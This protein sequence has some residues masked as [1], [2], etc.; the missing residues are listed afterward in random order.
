MDT[1]NDT[2]R[3]VDALNS[4]LR[5]ELSAVETYEQAI[6]K[7]IDEPIPELEENRDSHAD[8][9]TVLSARVA[10]LGGIPETSSGAWGAFAKLVEGGAELFGRDAAIA[11]LEEGEDRGLND[12]RTALG[13]LD[14]DSRVVVVADLLPAQ[15][16]THERMSALKRQDSPRARLENRGKVKV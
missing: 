2:K 3:S 1:R 5:G 4:L 14:T 15:E 13:K 6:A 9:V 10:A 7:T 8:R 11:A 12:Y 16:R